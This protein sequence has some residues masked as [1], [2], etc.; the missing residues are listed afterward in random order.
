[1]MDAQG[2]S[3]HSIEMG[4][5]MLWDEYKKGNSRT[6]KDMFV[7]VVETMAD[8]VKGEACRVQ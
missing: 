8:C 6:K 7:F 5:R 2:R 3:K 1:M 4:G